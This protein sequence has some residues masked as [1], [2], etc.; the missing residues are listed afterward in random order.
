MK[1]YTFILLGIVILT[2][3]LF[4]RA[5]SRAR[6]AT[7]LPRPR[8]DHLQGIDRGPLPQAQDELQNILTQVQDVSREYIAKLDTKIR[9]LQQLL[10]QADQ[11]K[12]ELQKLLGSAPPPPP[13][14][15]KPAVERPENPLHTKV[16]RLADAGE[17]ISAIEAKTGLGRGEVEL[18]LA[19]RKKPS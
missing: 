13:P 1:E 14:P 12:A 3:T 17:E 11:C 5:R 7:S 9:I 6:G 2:V 15:A 19:L 8:F 4:M 16:Y 18:I 10:A